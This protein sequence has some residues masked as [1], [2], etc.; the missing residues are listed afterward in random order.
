MA[1]TERRRFIW[2]WQPRYGRTYTSAVVDAGGRDLHNCTRHAPGAPVMVYLRSVND[3]IELRVEDAGPGFSLVHT[4]KGLGLG[5]LSM[6]ERART[7]GGSF[8]LKSSHGEGTVVLVTA[9]LTEHGRPL[10]NPARR[11]SPIDG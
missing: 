3:I 7:V 4:E 1:E 2:P 11:G 5:L 9:P 10:P 6:Q 8:Q